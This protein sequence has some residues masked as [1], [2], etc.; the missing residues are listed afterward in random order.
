M[1]VQNTAEVIEISSDSGNEVEREHNTEIIEIFSS[2]EDDGDGIGK[3]KVHPQGSEDVPQLPKTDVAQHPG[4]ERPV[5]KKSLKETVFQT[6]NDKQG[7]RIDGEEDR[8]KV[9]C[10][11]GPGGRQWWWQPPNGALV[12]EGVSGIKR[13]A[14]SCHRRTGMR[15]EPS[16]PSP[17]LSTHPVKRLFHGTKVGGKCCAAIFLP[18]YLQ[19][20]LDHGQLIDPG[21]LILLH[22]RFTE[23][24]SDMLAHQGFSGPGT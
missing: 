6:G 5:K 19:P 14:A 11:D 3:S 8:S 1:T 7:H 9:A 22:C 18:N 4:S 2:S 24:G 23:P 10:G 16:K 21:W 17:E 15:D 12:T 13:A 20:A